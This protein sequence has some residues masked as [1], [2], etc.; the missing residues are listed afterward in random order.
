M[1]RR[2]EMNP[3]T[4]AEKFGQA[5]RVGF[6]WDRFFKEDWPVE[7]IQL[8]NKDDLS[9]CFM[10]WY[11]GK[12]GHEVAYDDPD[13]IPMCLTDVPKATHILNDERQLDIHEYVKSFK[14]DAVPIEFSAPTYSLP[15]DKYFVLDRNHRLS[16][17]TLS[18]VPF[19]VTLW[20]VRGPQE[21]DGL[22]DFRHWLPKN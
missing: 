2:E 5:I 14:R 20:N 8:R 9:R 3:I 11:I 17:L 7:A 1:G 22:L 6:N 4:F 16:A 15:D 21:P 18:S 12:K 13:A 10:P 19:N